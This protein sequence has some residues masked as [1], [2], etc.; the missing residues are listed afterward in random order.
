MAAD[1]AA[2]QFSSAFRGEEQ[3]EQ[4]RWISCFGVAETSRIPSKMAVKGCRIKR[5]RPGPVKRCG[6]SSRKC[7]ENT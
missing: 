1:S 4:V 7:L 6:N 3:P 5:R 2:Q